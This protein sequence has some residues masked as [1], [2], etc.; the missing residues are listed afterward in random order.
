MSARR[1]PPRKKKGAA[2][3][4]RRFAGTLRDITSQASELGVTPKT[5]RAQVARGL[6]PYRKLGGRIMF[7]HDEVRDYLRQPPA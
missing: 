5:L 4:P 6:I 7:L 2:Q 1:S 3:G